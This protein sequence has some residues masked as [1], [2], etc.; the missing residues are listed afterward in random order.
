[1]KIHFRPIK[2]RAISSV[3]I[4]QDV[5]FKKLQQCARIDMTFVTTMLNEQSPM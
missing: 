1:M 3:S 5:D 4:V 2:H